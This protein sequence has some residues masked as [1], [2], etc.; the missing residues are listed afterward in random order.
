VNMA[1]AGDVLATINAKTPT[2]IKPV[3]TM[4]IRVKMIPDPVA[5]IGGKSQGSMSAATFRAQIGPYAAMKNFEFDAKFQITTFQF[6]LLP[7]RGEL[8]G[9]FT[10]TNPNGCRFTDSKDIVTAMPRIR[11]GDRVFIES[12]KAVGPDKRTRSLNPIILLMN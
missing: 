11:P 6:S 7:K 8:I 1:Q 3:G 12:I 4:K 10:V 5:E 9:P 2:G